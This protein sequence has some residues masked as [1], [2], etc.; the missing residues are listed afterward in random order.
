MTTSSEHR[1]PTPEEGT[2]HALTATLSPQSTDQFDEWVSEQLQDL[3]EH[4]RE[5]VSPRSLQKSLRG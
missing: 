2:W 3:E 4:L 5:F 1:A